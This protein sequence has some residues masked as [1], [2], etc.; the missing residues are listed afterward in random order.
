MTVQQ[1]PNLRAE[2]QPPWVDIQ[3]YQQP[4]VV[5]YGNR[6]TDQGG[7]LPNQTDLLQVSL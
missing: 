4:S 7:Q 1:I 3:P 5:S 6:L 2:H